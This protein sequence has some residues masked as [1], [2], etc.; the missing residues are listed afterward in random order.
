MGIGKLLNL[1]SLQTL[2]RRLM[3]DFSDLTKKGYS[4]DIMSGEFGLKNG[5]AT[6]KDGYINGPVADVGLKGYID[7]AESYY[8]MT[9]DVRPH[10]T[11]SLPLIATIVGTPVAGIITWMVNKAVVS[12]IVGRIARK[13]IHMQGYLDR[14][15]TPK[16]TVKEYHSN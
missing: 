13:V 10:L 6:I 12:P 8:D 2:P 3:L 16:V 9:A 1:L 14:V 11:S 5:R 15:D 7:F 4:F